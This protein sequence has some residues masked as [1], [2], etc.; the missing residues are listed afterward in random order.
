[1]LVFDSRCFFSLLVYFCLGAFS[2]SFL[3]S[4]ILVLNNLHVSPMYAAP[5]LLHLV[6]EF[7]L[8][9]RFYIAYGCA[10][11]RLRVVWGRSGHPVFL[12]YPVNLSEAPST[13]G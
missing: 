12:Q 13:Y 3:C 4:Y 8:F 11:I 7:T 2:E 1:M 10:D 9:F 6:H 5:Q